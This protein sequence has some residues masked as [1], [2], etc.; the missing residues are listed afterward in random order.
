M[1]IYL[2]RHGETDWNHINRFQGRENIPLNESGIA[3]AQAAGKALRNLDISAVYTSPLQRAVRTGEE[4]ASEIGLSPDRVHPLQNLIERDL[5]PFSGQLVKDSKEYFALAASENA[6]GMEPFSSVLSRMEKALE[7]LESSGYSS[8]AAVSHGAA[9]N[10][11]LAGL[12]NH[13]LGTGKTKLYNGG[14]S[15]IEGNSDNG[16]RI[17]IC[18][19]RPEDFPN[20]ISS[21]KI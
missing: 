9:I 6:T 4:I 8:V 11:L 19:S 17:T 14:I 13:E 18:N 10:V 20:R 3:Q 16:F 5:G 2:I 1:K 15:L 7:E 21:I 12:S